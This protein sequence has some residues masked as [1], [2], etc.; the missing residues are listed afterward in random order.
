MYEI[1]SKMIFL[2]RI[3]LE[4]YN[5]VAIASKLILSSHLHSDY[6]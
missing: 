5:L 1:Y 3:M 6:Q 4:T 2:C